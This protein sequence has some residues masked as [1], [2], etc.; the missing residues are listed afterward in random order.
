[1]DTLRSSRPSAHQRSPPFQIGK[2]LLNHTYAR[3]KYDIGQEPG[4]RDSVHAEHTGL[5]L[6][7]VAREH[8]PN[9]RLGK[10]P[11]RLDATN[12]PRA[13]AIGVMEPKTDASG[14]TLFEES[15]QLPGDDAGAVSN[16]RAS[17]LTDN[18]APA[19]RSEVARLCTGQVAQQLGQRRL[20]GIPPR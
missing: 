11:M 1:M 9:R 12:R 8:V 17:G 15:E 14:K 3:P 2:L 19:E 20:C 18:D 7:E 16:L 4:P 6:V 5:R 10:E 13:F